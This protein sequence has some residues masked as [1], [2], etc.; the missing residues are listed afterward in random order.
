MSKI[1]V[2]AESFTLRDSNGQWLGQVLLTSDG[3]FASV[4]D[5]GN[6]SYA[7]RSFG[8]NFKEFIC[9]L[10]ADYF[11][12]K[13][14]QGFAYVLYNKKVEAAA[15]RFSEKIL[16]ALQEVLKRELEDSKGPTEKNMA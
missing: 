13:M 8:D 15:K 12:N 2:T 4:T 5:Y 14:N 16:P 3:M 11:A 1:E 9:D 10:S 6:F 7:W